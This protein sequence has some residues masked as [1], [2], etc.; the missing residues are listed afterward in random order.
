MN[1]QSTA[2]ILLGI[3]CL[4]QGLA[5]VI[6]D[7]NRTHAAHPQ[8]LGHARFHVVWQTVTAMVLAIVEVWLVWSRGP[9][10]SERFYVTAILA[11][12]PMAGFFGALVSRHVYGGTLSDPG[13]IPPVHIKLRGREMQVDMNL[14]AE[15]AGV[16]TVAGLVGLYR[17]GG[18]RG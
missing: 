7:L 11:S 16:I 12:A 6:L 8:W 15:I 4:I 5:T 9:L 18:P 3:F 1:L 2:R 13:G 10:I 14:V 17:F